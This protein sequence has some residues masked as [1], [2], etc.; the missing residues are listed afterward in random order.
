MKKAYERKS[1]MGCSINALTPDQQNQKL[2][3]GLV[4][5][6]AFSITGM[7]EVQLSTSRVKGKIPIVRI[8]C[9]CILIFKKINLTM[10]II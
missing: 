6:H 4:S 8:R 2:P 9:V 3:N 5:G 1:F 10:I 7:N